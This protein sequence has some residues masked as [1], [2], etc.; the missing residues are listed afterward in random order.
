MAEFYLDYRVDDRFHA[1]FFMLFVTE[2]G[3]CYVGAFLE[4]AVE[5]SRASKVLAI[6]ASADKS[7]TRGC[8][9][10]ASKRVRPCLD[11]A[12]RTMDSEMVNI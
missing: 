10:R 4:E 5:A 12:S 11:E 7:M 8:R 9:K 6:E 1:S 3:R 2:A